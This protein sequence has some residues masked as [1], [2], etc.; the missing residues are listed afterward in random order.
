MTLSSLT[1]EDVTQTLR[2]A[3]ELPDGELIL[4]KGDFSLTIRKG[5]VAAD[6]LASPPVRQAEPQTPP[7]TLLMPQ[8]ASSEETA[9]FVASAPEPAS[10]AGHVIL[11]A[12]MLGCFYRSSSPGEP[13]LADIGS[14]VAAG[15]AVCLIEV[16]KLFNTIEAEVSGTIIAIHADNGAMVDAGTPLFSVK[17]D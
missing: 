1:H 14:H 13:P 5:V 12:P 3:E 9:E 7:S 15:D 8:P 6:A 2:L 11:R 4:T 10:E 16:M 17:P